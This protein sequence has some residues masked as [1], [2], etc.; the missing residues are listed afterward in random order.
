MIFRDNSKP[1]ALHCL[2][3]PQPEFLQ[4]ASCCVSLGELQQDLSRSKMS[5]SQLST[6]SHIRYCLLEI[7]ACYLHLLLHG[8]PRGNRR[9]KPKM[10]LQIC[11]HNT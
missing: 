10:R 4:H 9:Q 2:R 3:D 11:I 7:I 1:D 6:L 8:L 5:K